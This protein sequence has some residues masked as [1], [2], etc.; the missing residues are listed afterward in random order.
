MNHQTRWRI[1]AASIFAAVLV[2]AGINLVPAQSSQRAVSVSASD[3]GHK[4]CNVDAS[5]Y[6]TV[7]H[8]LGYTPA[9]VVVMADKIGQLAATDQFTATT[10]RA[11]F[12]WYEP[13]LFAAG[14]QIGFSWKPAGEVVTTPTSPPASSPTVS[15]PPTSTTPPTTTTPAPTP[16]DTAS[17]VKTCTSSTPGWFTTTS[18]NN[19]GDGRTYGKYFVH[20]NM[21]NN[22]NGTYTLAACN[23]DNWY[24]LATQPK[25]GDNGVQTYPNV[26]KD[27]SNVAL[28]NADGTP[29][30]RSSKFAAKT[31]ATCTGCVYDVAYDIWL[32]QNFSN[33]LMIWTDNKGQTPAGTKQGTV[34]FAGQTYDVWHD[35]GYTAYVS[36]VTQK[37][38][39]MPLASFFAD[40]KS[41]GWLPTATTWQVDYGVEI[42]S[43]A[44]VQQ[45]F[46]FTDFSIDDD[47]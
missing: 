4:F 18:T 34:T 8:N 7:T 9:G 25:P 31:P 16:T 39:T 35:S 46:D 30:I 28:F 32:G 13:G 37:Y 27:Y 3:G 5:G 44:G 6:C 26:H 10:F 14:T 36:Q 24:E 29:K 20:N 17:P 40:M 43:T 12:Y 33:E 38:G 1:V 11:R 23:Y 19:Q 22:S 45:R 47:Y 42:V 41:R 2:A 21:W 15:T